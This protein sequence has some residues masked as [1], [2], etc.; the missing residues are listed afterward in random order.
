MLTGRADDTRDGALLALSAR[1]CQHGPD[2][3]YTH[4]RIP[5]YEYR[6][7]NGHT[8]DAL[9]K[10]ADEPLT[11]CEVCGAPARRVLHPV[12]IHIKASAFYT[13]DCGRGNNKPRERKSESSASINGAK[14]APASK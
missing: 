3:R 7:D 14:N 4:L 12:A 10:F 1:E 5:I 8:F 6:C 9:Q 2:G 11:E 13:T